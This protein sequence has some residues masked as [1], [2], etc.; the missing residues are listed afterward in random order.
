LTILLPAT[1]TEYF[2]DSISSVLSQTFRDFRVIVGDNTSDAK[3]INAFQKEFR[4][5][6]IEWLHSYPIT[7]GTIE[8]HSELLISRIETEYVR[9][10][11]D[12]DI[13]YQTSNQHLMQLIESQSAVFAFHGRHNI[14]ANG[15]IIGAHHWIN[16]PQIIR[17]DAKT[18]AN[19]TYKS[20]SNL[21]SEPSFSVYRSSV[22]R[23][24]KTDVDGIPIKF[25][26]DIISPLRAAELGHIVGSSL[27]LGAFRIHG[28]QESGLSSPIRLAGIYEWELIARHLDKKYQFSQSDF[29]DCVAR[30]KELYS[31]NKQYF[32]VIGNFLNNL[33]ES[34][35]NN[36]FD[37]WEVFKTLVLDTGLYDK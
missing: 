30:L 29:R 11:F 15:R 26:G 24:I 19:L 33:A 32:D 8:R 22:L 3:V 37:R 13:I 36:H 28:N 17:L 27:L 25:L 21:F 5:H 7:G 4:D 2:A 23:E 6:R 16:S 35:A 1:R 20:C 10:V 12:D 31:H 34:E 9:F 14:D 18:A